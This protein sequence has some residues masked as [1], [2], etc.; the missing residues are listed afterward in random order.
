[1]SVFFLVDYCN[2]LFIALSTLLLIPFTLQSTV[3]FYLIL[4]GYPQNS[5]RIVP[6]YCAGCK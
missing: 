2:V 3:K 4:A 5:Q 6:P 1:M